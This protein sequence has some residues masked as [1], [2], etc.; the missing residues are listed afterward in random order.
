[1]LSTVTEVQSFTLAFEFV[2]CLK[3]TLKKTGIYVVK[4]CQNLQMK[5]YDVDFMLTEGKAWI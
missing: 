2:R 5:K 1:M 4:I 3:A